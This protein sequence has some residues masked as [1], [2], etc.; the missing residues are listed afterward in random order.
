MTIDGTTMTQPPIA[1]RYCGNQLKRWRIQTDVSR[2]DLAREAGYS[3]EA[4]KSMEQGRR[5]PTRRVL[6]IADD[7]CDARGK[8]RAA[9]DYLEPEKY[10][11]RT[12]EFMQAEA[13]ALALH[14]YENV[15]IPGL[16]QTEEYARALLDAHCPPL[17]DETIEQRLTARMQRREKLES[18]PTSLFTFVIYEAALRTSV[19]G[20]E[21]MRRQLEH[22][23]DM[24]QLRNV[25]VQVLPADTGAHAGLNGA[26]VLLE[27]EEREHYAYEESHEMRYLYGDPE[28]VRVL[29][30]RHGM[31]RMQALNAEQSARFLRRVA[32]E[33]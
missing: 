27:T 24:G 13:S 14:S 19:G 12:H 4:I 21:T 26:F 5:K 2:E 17:D 29:R 3:Y 8:L 25:S 23:A 30:E 15:F 18:K 9:T 28:K 20:R 33:L 6:D 32:A 22:V 7:M 1:W 31:I 16:L 11:A 10:P